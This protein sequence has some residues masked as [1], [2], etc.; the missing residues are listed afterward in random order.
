MKKCKHEF[1]EVYDAGAFEYCKHCNCT[2]SE[3]K[4]EELEQQLE[5]AVEALEKYADEKNWLE[6][7][8]GPT[9]YFE[10]TEVDGYLIAKQALARI[11]N[12]K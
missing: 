2:P 3:A 9:R 1:K 8:L 4:I 10:N 12:L 11:K 5:V 6:M 7:F